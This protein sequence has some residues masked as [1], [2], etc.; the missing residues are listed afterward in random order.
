MRSLPWDRRARIAEVRT[1][2]WSYVS[3]ASRFEVPGLLTAAALLQWP[4]ADALRL[5]AL[6]F[7]LSAEVGEM[8][9]AMPQLIRRLATAS[10]S[11]E[12]QTVDR[13]RGPVQWNRTFALR[14]ASG[15]PLLFVTAPVSAIL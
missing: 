14:A 5:G 12:E 8:F 11:S 1:R 6:Q 7:L 4:E 10:A 13:L 3:P 2:I 9:A 15:S